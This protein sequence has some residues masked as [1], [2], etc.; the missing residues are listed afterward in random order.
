MKDWDYPQ[1]LQQLKQSMEESEENIKELTK[2][3]DEQHK[4]NHKEYSMVDKSLED[5]LKGLKTT[6]F[7]NA[8]FFASI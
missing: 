4:I 8:Q 6:Q 3:I 5:Y 7:N 2:F 1:R